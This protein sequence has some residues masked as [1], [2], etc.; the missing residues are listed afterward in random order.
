MRLVC[1][2][3]ACPDRL[4]GVPCLQVVAPNGIRRA[5]LKAEQVELVP[6]FLRGT[7]VSSAPGIAD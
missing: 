4:C 7:L 3:G 6:R 5:G 1:G 2:P